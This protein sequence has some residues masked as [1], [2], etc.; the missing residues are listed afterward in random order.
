VQETKQETA[1]HDIWKQ[2][3]ERNWAQ[4][5]WLFTA[6]GLFSFTYRS[7]DGIA[8]RQPVDWSARFI[9]EMTGAYGALLLFPVLIWFTLSLPRWMKKGS[10]AGRPVRAALLTIAAVIVYGFLHTT[11]MYVARLAVFAAIGRGVYD[12]GVLPMR[13]LMEFPMQ[14]IAFV[15]ILYVIRSGEE[16]RIFERFRQRSIELERELTQAKLEALQYQLQPHFLFNALNVISA[17]VHEDAKAA[18]RML[19]RLAEF[20]RRVL[21][22]DKSLE[23]PVRDEID[24]VRL[25]LDVM[26]ARFEERLQCEVTCA[27]ETGDALVPQLILQPLVENAI[28]HGMDPSTGRVSLS[29][30]VSRNREELELR[31]VDR[32]SGHT[33]SNGS[34]F[35][36]G[37]KNAGTR[38]ERLYGKHA[39]LKLEN[40]PQSTLVRIALPYHI[41]PVAQPVAQPAGEPA[42]HAGPAKGEFHER[43]PLL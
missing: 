12:Y 35:G 18:D 32:G 31:V 27:P 30:E 21:A 5:F 39:S 37:L 7:M 15:V 13:Y 14:V 10:S 8:R 38:L 28:R 19:S 25:Y 33:S 26:K 9:E 2:V 1:N 34:G 22:S 16:Q 3:R 20:L 43:L 11:F 24:L 17:L 40:S 23:V 41:Q 29:V 6:I 36:V 42:N 4:S